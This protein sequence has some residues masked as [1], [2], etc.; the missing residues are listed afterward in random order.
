MWAV[1]AVTGVLVVGV[2]VTFAFGAWFVAVPLSLVVLGL[3]L[4][5][6]ASGRVGDSGQ[7]RRFRAKA[8]E[9]A[10]DRDSLAK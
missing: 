3:A 9:A 10:P 2:V 7:L 6:R 8:G 1:W 4:A 5:A